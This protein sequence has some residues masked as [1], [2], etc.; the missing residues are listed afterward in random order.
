MCCDCAISSY[1]ST[2]VRH[3]SVRTANVLTNRHYSSNLSMKQ[4]FVR[5]TISQEVPTALVS[6]I[7]FMR[8]RMHLRKAAT[9]CNFPV[10]VLVVHIAAAAKLRRTCTSNLSRTAGCHY[11]KLWI[12]CGRQSS[13]PRDGDVNLHLNCVLS[14]TPYLHG[15]LS[16]RKRR[17]RN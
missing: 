7:R 15:S 9:Q 14:H 6:E 4:S 12:P 17:E 2:I 5:I 1:A 11:G 8:C 16:L 10:Q 13:R 3:A